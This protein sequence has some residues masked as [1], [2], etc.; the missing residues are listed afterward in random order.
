MPTM[1]VYMLVRFKSFPNNVV[2][3]LSTYRQ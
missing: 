3:F 1:V 2:K